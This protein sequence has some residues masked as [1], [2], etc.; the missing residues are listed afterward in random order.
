[1]LL[2]KV[3]DKRHFYNGHSA[4]TLAMLTGNMR[5]LQAFL[6]SGCLDPNEILGENLGTALH[7][8]VST[9]MQKR[10]AYENSMKMVGIFLSREILN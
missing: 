3:S 2:V 9:T 1:M 6:M 4:L 8:L 7:V 10:T 5:L